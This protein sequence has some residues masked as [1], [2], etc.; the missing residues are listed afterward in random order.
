MTR[1]GG[2][3]WRRTLGGWRGT[4]DL[5]GH[6]PVRAVLEGG[7]IRPSP[8]LVA[9]VEALPARWPVLAA[10]AGGMLRREAREAGLAVDEGRGLP[11]GAVP[12]HV[13]A[14]TRRG[15]TLVEVGVAVAW[16]EEHLRGVEIVDGVLA[17][18]NGSVRS[19]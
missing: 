10:V 9:A 19:R 15:R 18:L 2:P 6:G 3:Y 5:P 13:V 16:D 7:L 17:G 8:A 1:A 11:A 14:A 12:V 4:A